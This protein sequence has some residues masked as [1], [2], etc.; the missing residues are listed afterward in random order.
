MKRH[1]FWGQIGMFLATMLLIVSCA[2]SNSP[3]PSASESAKSSQI[4]QVQVGFSIW[5]GW[6]PWEITSQQRLVKSATLPVSFRW[7]DSYTDS[8]NA[9]SKGDIQANSQ[10][11]NDT[12]ASVSGGSDQVV[13]LVNDYS[14]GND[15]IIVR[16]GIKSIADLKGKKIAVENGTVD[17]FLLLLGLQ[18]AALTVQDV[19]LV[20]LETSKAAEAFAAGQVDAAAVFAPFTSVALKRSGSKE[21]FSSKDHPG[22]IADHLV[23]SRQMVK[24]HPEQVQSLVDSW[25]D[26]LTKVQKDP[27]SNLKLMAQRA[28]VSLDEYKQYANGTKILSLKENLAALYP[29]RDDTSL[30]YISERIASFMVDAN[31]AKR[32]P[33]LG[34][35]FDDQFVKAYAKKHPEQAA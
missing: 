30:V 15:K 4:D 34:G 19:T 32:R 33:D 26:T 13:V 5:P 18:K 17:H 31:L 20:P 9:L 14:T 35:M 2:T 10:T 7:F 23:V 16:D 24:E 3:T 29:A 21:L 1:S 6:L 8:I 12:I 22:A 11:L 25:F 28:G 27:E